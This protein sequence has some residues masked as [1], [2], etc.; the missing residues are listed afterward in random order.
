MKIYIILFNKENMRFQKIILI[1][2]LASATLI[3]IYLYIWSTKPEL[4]QGTELGVKEA[5]EIAMN[6]AKKSSPLVFL[7][8]NIEG[9]QIETFP[10][11]EILKRHYVFR[12]HYTLFNIVPSKTLYV[13]VDK[14]TGQASVMPKGFKD[15]IEREDISITNAQEALNLVHFYIEM[16]KDP[17]GI[18]ILLNQAQDIPSSSKAGIKGKDPALY[19]Q[20]ISEPQVTKEGNRFLVHVFTWTSFGGILEEWRLEVSQRAEVTV[21]ESRVIDEKIGGYF[22]PL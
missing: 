17:Y 8:G 18:V 15:V 12:V 20:I 19:A 21:R 16:Q 1:I 14:Q 22:V 10:S 13:L 9:A 2:G 3:G 5:A 6:T 4:Y 7:A 11:A